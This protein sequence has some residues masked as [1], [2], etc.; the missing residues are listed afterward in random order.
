MGMKTVYNCNICGDKKEKVEHLF[1]VNFSSDKTFDLGGYGS[2]DRIHICYDCA[3]QL[4]VHLTDP[5][6]TKLLDKE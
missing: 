1:G 2:T 5:Q 4:R 3:R 6:I